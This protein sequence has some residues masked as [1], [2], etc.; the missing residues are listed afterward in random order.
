MALL[1]EVHP[2]EQGLKPWLGPQGVQQRIGFEKDQEGGTFRVRLLQC[3]KR[4]FFVI[5]RNVDGRDPIL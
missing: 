4:A 5:E 3:V 2:L 1:R